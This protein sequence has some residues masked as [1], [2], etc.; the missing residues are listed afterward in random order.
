MDINKLAGVLLGSDSISGLS[1]LADVSGTDVNSVL[2]AALPAL[3]NGANDQAKGKDTTEGFA[4]ALAQH[5][6]ADTKDVT[7]FLG[8]VDLEDGAKIIGHLLGAKK[9]DVTAS[10]A[11]ETGVSNKKTEMILSAVGPLLMSLLGQQAD[12]D[13]NKGSGVEVL[14]GALLENV[15]LVELLTGTSSEGT[16]KKGSK[17]KNSKKKAA[18]KEDSSALGSIMNGLFKLLK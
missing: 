17:K 5:A 3:L 9:E 16:G 13:E 15:D 8:N 10:V 18:K 4:N 14:L 11:E 2:A 7:G 6:K 12:E 1:N